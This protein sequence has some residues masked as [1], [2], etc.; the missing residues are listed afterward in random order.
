MKPQTLA[1]VKE[2]PQANYS[3]FD[4]LDGRHSFQQA[5]PDAYVEYKVRTRHGGSVYYF[6]FNLA[7][8]MGLISKEHPD[9]LTPALEKK[10]LETFAIVII[11][12]YDIMKGTKFDE[13]DI[14]PH[15]YMATRYLQLQHANKRGKTSGDGRGIWNGEFRQGGSAWDVSSSGTGATKLSPAHAQTKQFFKTGDNRV[16]YG[17]GYNCVSDGLSAALLSEVFHS[18]DVGTERT[19][20]IISFEGGSSIN[21][22]AGK[23]LFRP[24]HFFRQ[25]KMGDLTGLKATVDFFINR[26]VQNK[27]WPSSGS[28][29]KSVRYREFAEQ[30]ALSFSKIAA[31]FEAEYIF[32]WLDWDGDNILAN[33]GIIDY[34]SIRQFGL[35]HWEYRYDDVDRMSTNI[36]EQ[37][38][39]ARYI[40]QNFAQI[41]DFLLTGK[42]KNIRSFANDPIVKLFDRNFEKVLLQILLKKLGFSAKQGEYLLQNHSKQVKRL[43]KHHSYFEKTK[44]A[45]GVYKIDDG[46]TC[47]AIFCMADLHRELPKKLQEESE[48]APSDFIDLCRSSYAKYVDLRISSYRRKEIRNFLQS[49]RKLVKLVAEKFHRGNEKKVLVEMTMRAS[50][51]NRQ[52]RM[53][54]DGV[55]DVTSSLMRNHHRLT[56][57]QQNEVIEKIIQHQ[58]RE[59]KVEVNPDSKTGKIVL[60]NLKAI[61]QYREGS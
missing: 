24:A 52:D 55:L 6:N 14:R 57:E 42:K 27:E 47:D 17:N 56:F 23:N 58:S 11:N 10:I 3:S 15:P 18:N 36:P 26:Q 29:R 51:S 33:G 25:C 30:M 37:R 48:L 45:K 4:Q 28:S 41:R 9:E 50:L 22:R 20:A 16:G 49:Y 39:K 35:Y 32:C 7:R 40:V 8:E 1:S 21:V 5:V 44:S 61:R 12:E 13:R 46:I 2:L 53:T 43:K 60:R 31:Q 34:G 38:L 19:L 59:A 54:G